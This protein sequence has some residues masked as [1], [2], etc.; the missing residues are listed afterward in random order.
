MGRKLALATL[1]REHVGWL[2][3][4]VDDGLSKLNPGRNVVLSRRGPPVQRVRTASFSFRQRR[5]GWW[6]GRSSGLG[7]VRCHRNTE[8]PAR[9]VGCRSERA[10]QNGRRVPGQACARERT[11]EA[12]GRM[13]QVPLLRWRGRED[14]REIDMARGGVAGDE[15]VEAVE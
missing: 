1:V 6:C 10:V 2:R 11:G 15:V 12:R 9:S 14:S 4:R 5:L 3:A 7:R 8:R 13:Q